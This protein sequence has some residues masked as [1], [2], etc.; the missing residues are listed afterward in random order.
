MPKQTRRPKRRS[1]KAQESEEAQ[2][3][4]SQPSRSTSPQP[5]AVIRPELLPQPSVVIS[6]EPHPVVTRQG[7]P[8]L[9]ISPTHSISPRQSTP[10]SPRQSTPISPRRITPIQERR[11]SLRLPERF[12]VKE[13]EGTIEAEGSILK[14]VDLFTVYIY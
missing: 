11:P 6:L 8:P 10:I 14:V 7:P 5:S 1:A 4:S 12:S 3:T 9:R 13:Y 2:S